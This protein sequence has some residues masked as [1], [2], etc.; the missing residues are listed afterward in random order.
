[1]AGTA[2][3]RQ[4][5]LSVSGA[6]ADTGTRP[7][8]DRG[9][10]RIRRGHLAPS[11]RDRQN[12]RF[13]VGDWL[14]QTAGCRRRR[15]LSVRRILRK[16]RTGQRFDHN[17]PPR[18]N[19]CC[20]GGPVQKHPTGFGHQSDLLAHAEAPPYLILHGTDDRQSPATERLLYRRSGHW[21]YRSRIT[22]CWRGHASDAFVQPGSWT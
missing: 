12:R 20:F 7:R 13:D 17:S 10:R 11:P 8:G 4:I 19:P 5:P 21:K 15:F 18:R 3:G 6:H 14:D 2:R 9:G 1:M 16:W 22:G